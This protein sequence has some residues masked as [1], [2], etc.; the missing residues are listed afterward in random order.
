MRLRKLLIGVLVNSCLFSTANADVLFQMSAVPGQDI[1][2]NLTG[3]WAGGGTM[4]AKV[5][6]INIKCDYYGNATV[7][8]PSTDSYVVDVVFDLQ[9]GSAV[10]PG[11]QAYTLPGTCDSQT[12]AIVL[13]TND[14]QLHG[15][16]DS[17]GNQATLQGTVKINIMNRSVTGNVNNLVLN[18]Q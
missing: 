4:T 17:A 2:E 12:G 7:T 5:I 6:G 9:S 11:Q 10:C 18:K 16:I 15:N 13:K 3:P 1:C 8:K 14:V